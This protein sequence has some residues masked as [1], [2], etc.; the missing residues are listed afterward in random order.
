MANSTKIEV[1]G[2]REL[3]VALKALP[4]KMTQRVLNAALMKGA[5]DIANEAKKRAPVLNPM[6]STAL[7]GRRRAGTLRRNIRARVIRAYEHTA[8]V[9]VGVR[10]LSSKAIL[11]FKKA[12]GKNGAANPDDPFYWRFLGFGTS[13]MRARPFLRP[14]FE[15]KK[16]A[17]ANVIKDAIKARLEVEAKKLNTR[18]VR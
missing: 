17:A 2:L 12:T 8:S 3:Q 5:R 16:F 7:K 4:Q 13:K 10:Q 11:A 18:V 14:A 1:Q 15:T 9:M 6:D